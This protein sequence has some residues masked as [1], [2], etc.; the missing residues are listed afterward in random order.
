MTDL[1]I[2][3]ELE[4]AR[5]KNNV[6]WMNIIRLAFK[7]SPVEARKIISQI[8]INDNEISLILDKLSKN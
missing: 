5:A 6:N 8:N 3:D 1:E 4:K 2:L 7:K